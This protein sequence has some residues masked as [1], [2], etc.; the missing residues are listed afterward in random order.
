MLWEQISYRDESDIKLP[1]TLV[2]IFLSQSQKI[3]KKKKQTIITQS[4][5]TTDIYYIYSGAVKISIL[6][7][8]SKEYIFREVG[9]GNLIG[10][11]AAFDGE[12]RSVTVATTED[13]IFYK[14]NRTVFLNLV[15]NNKEFYSY[16]ITSLVKRVRNLSEQVFELSTMNVRCRIVLDIIR[17][18]K[19]TGID[20]NRAEFTL[21][22]DQLKIATELSTHREAISREYGA[23][24]KSKLIEKNAQKI[25]IPSFDKLEAVFSK[26]MGL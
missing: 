6:A 25:I 9:K 2:E 19:K 26:M 11:L 1:E 20:N 5:D 14:M 18:A 15:N 8:N 12:K 16:L 22:K 23:L 4:D 13:T 7:P 10:E 21:P 24:V 3:S 17:R